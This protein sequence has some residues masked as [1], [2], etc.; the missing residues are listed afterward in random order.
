MFSIPATVN[1]MGHGESEVPIS[2]LHDH[3]KEPESGEMLAV[4]I[5]D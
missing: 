2:G 1:E 4:V 3:Y 5:C